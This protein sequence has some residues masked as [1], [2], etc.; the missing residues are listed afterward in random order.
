MRPLR[1]ALALLPLAA[2]CASAPDADPYG[3]LYLHPDGVIELH[4][5]PEG[6]LRGYLGTGDRIA[7]LAPVVM[8]A[9]AFEASAGYDDGTKAELRA[10]LRPG[11]ALV[12]DGRE[13]RRSAVE[14]P[15]DAKV[16]GEIEEAYARL[17]KAVET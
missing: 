10:A 17:A 8:D 13:Y 16:R 3:G 4:R 11:P 2:A 9:G 1:S 5:G 15:A 7:A 14:R 6:S 12:L